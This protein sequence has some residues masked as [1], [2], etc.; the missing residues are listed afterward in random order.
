MVRYVNHQINKC[1]T[2]KIVKVWSLQNDCQ[3]LSVGMYHYVTRVY[4][5]NLS[6][7][8]RTPELSFSFERLY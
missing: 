3:E 2:A 7:L 8:M 1:L 5:Q 6:Q 4:I